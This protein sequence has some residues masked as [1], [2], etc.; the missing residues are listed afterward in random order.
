MCMACC[1]ADKEE[2]ERLARLYWLTSQME[3][4]REKL[5]VRRLVQSK[6]NEW[7]SKAGLLLSSVKALRL[8]GCVSEPVMKLANTP[9]GWIRQPCR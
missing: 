9:V 8:A 3:I 2:L 1:W 5:E 7:R 4:P 6:L